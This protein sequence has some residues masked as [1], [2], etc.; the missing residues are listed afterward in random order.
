MPS[1]GGEGF[2]PKPIPQLKEQVA[3]LS[4]KL[5]HPI[6]P[7]TIEDQ[8]DSITA[9]EIQQ[10]FPNR[11]R[12]YVD[13]LRQIRRDEHGINTLSPQAGVD[14]GLIARWKFVEPLIKNLNR[15]IQAQERGEIDTVS[16]KDR[17]MTIFEDIRD[18]IEDGETEGTI[19]AP[20][21]FGKT[22]IF[23]QLAA[24]LGVPTLIVVPSRYLVEQT[25]KRFQQFTPDI[26]VGRVYSDKK[27]YGRQVTI[28]T[29]DSLVR[30]TEGKLISPEGI[31]LV[32]LDESHKSGSK[33]R[34]QKVEAVEQF[35][36]AVIIGLSATPVEIRDPKFVNTRVAKMSK[37]LW[38]VV[39]ERE[40]IEEGYLSSF[41][42]IVVEVDVDLTNVG[43]TNAGN[44]SEE[45]LDKAINT[46]AQN[47]AAV[48]FFLQKREEDRIQREKAGKAP[49]PFITSWFSASVA[50]AKE[51]ARL[52]QEAGVRAAAVWGAHTAGERD[53]QRKILEQ[54]ERGEIEVVCSK[55]LLVQ[56]IDIAAMRCVMNVA[57]TASPIT[58]KQR[59]G[60]GLRYDENNP[61]GEVVIVDFVYNN[62]NKKSQ[63]VIYPELIG[64]ARIVRR[65]VFAKAEDRYG[66][67]R[68]D[69]AAQPV[70]EEI[71]IPGL[72]VIT[73]AAEIMRITNQIVFWREESRLVDPNQEIS[74]IESWLRSKYIGGTPKL[75]LAARTALRELEDM[76]PGA[77]RVIKIKGFDIPIFK[78]QYEGLL[79]SLMRKQE[80]D[81][82]SSFTKVDPEQEVVITDDFL[83]QNFES[84]SNKSDISDRVLAQLN[85]N[86]PGAS[87]VAIGAN[88]QKT[89]ALKKEHLE[90]Y[91]K[92]M[93]EQK[94]KLQRIKGGPVDSEREVGI[95]K[96]WL[97]NNFQRG[98]VKLNS[99]AEVAFEQIRKEH[100][101]AIRIG[102]GANGRGVEVIKKEYIGRFNQL[103]Q[104]YGVKLKG[105]VVNTETEVVLT[106]NFLRTRYAG[107]YAMLRV[108][109]DEVLAQMKE[110]SSGLVS[111]G[112]DNSGLDIINREYLSRY[113][114]LMQ[115][116]GIK[117]K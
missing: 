10:R 89:T 49:L 79:D 40:A 100:P 18:R 90:L 36:D 108:A 72:R 19:Q 92:L 78:R 104:E 47:E 86:Y 107:G 5:G 13:S 24:A 70:G 62:S 67:L 82:G 63:Q 77:T 117:F 53:E 99:A 37:N 2:R 6:T 115:A 28:T 110:E 87:R 98:K 17:Q 74:V 112:V 75:Q 52:L 42:S 66:G 21:G 81:L 116:R 56:G 30:D 8:L 7:V 35:K 57:P 4:T 25:R 68:S 26:S 33:D 15:H 3:T 48:S 61:D 106:T 39:P 114:E 71:N 54:W 14:G 22:V 93:I 80:V 111:D 73:S 50:Q 69:A 43:I 41:S 23:N 1:E 91:R 58:E 27:E 32:I 76:H 55:E 12:A 46:I 101:E 102:V 44:Y 9:D 60:R 11:Y 29:Y 109:S 20:T 97:V 95:T 65:Q 51:H 34:I 84:G 96:D 45:E 85:E 64:S 83:N 88:N 31:G 105:R 16:L 103:M 59:S 38:H 113:D 94:V